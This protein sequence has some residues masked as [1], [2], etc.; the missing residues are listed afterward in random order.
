[1]E[2]FTKTV[3]DNHEMVSRESN[4]DSV[5]AEQVVDGLDQQKLQHTLHD[6]KL[7]SSLSLLADSFLLIGVVMASLDKI[8]GIVKQAISGSVLKEI[9]ERVGHHIPGIIIKLFNV[10][11]NILLQAFATY[12]RKSIIFCRRR[13]IR[14]EISLCEYDLQK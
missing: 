3:H 11:F 7:E 14:I 9:H 2:R 6:D 10:C 13:N 8:F 12:A 1:M 4:I 5:S